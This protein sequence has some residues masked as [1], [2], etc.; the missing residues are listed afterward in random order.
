LPK[1]NLH[2]GSLTEPLELLDSAVPRHA[3]VQSS[4]I[5]MLLLYKYT[6]VFVRIVMQRLRESE[7]HEA[8][9]RFID[10]R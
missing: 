6:L 8:S 9:S 10:R 7:T 3:L 2:R 4:L 5:A 1:L